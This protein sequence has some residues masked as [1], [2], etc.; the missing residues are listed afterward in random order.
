MKWKGR[1]IVPSCQAPL[2][3]LVPSILSSANPPRPDN[4]HTK[5][6][7]KITISHR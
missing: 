1:T 7:H 4:N 3:A 6:G 5:V 2:R